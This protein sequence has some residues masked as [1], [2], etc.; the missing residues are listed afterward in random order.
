MNI[1]NEETADSI[2]ACIMLLSCCCCCWCCC[3]EGVGSLSD[4]FGGPFA[5]LSRVGCD[6]ARKHNF[7]L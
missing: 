2:C 3:C 5:K 7:Y 4:D 6:I 1:T